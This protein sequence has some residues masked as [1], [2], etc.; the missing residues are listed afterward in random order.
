MAMKPRAMKKK[1]MAMK[2]GGK[3]MMRGGMTK[4][5]T[6]MKRGGGMMMAKKPMAMKRGGSAKKTVRP[7]TKTMS[8]TNMIKEQINAMS[9]EKR[10]SVL[11]QMLEGKTPSIMK[12]FKSGP[13]Y[14]R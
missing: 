6:A 13:S 2:R 1:P 4:K 11:R 12:S 5:G 3:K 14:R 10:K 9:E 8:K 7:A